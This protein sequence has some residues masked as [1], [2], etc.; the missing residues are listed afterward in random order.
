MRVRIS[1]IGR[2]GLLAAVL[3]TLCMA[4][5]Q[6]AVVF[7]PYLLVSNQPGDF[8]VAIEE[9][10]ESL[11]DGGFKVVGEYSPYENAYVL[12]VTN[13]TLKR[14]AKRSEFGGFGAV[15]R[16]AITKVNGKNQI[17]YTNPHYMGNSYRMS[18]KGM[19]KVAEQLEAALGYGEPFGSEEGL[20]P[21]ELRK[22]HYKIFM[23]YF[24][25]PYLLATF[26][27]YKDAI[28]SI[29]KGLAKGEQGTSKV[30]RVDLPGKKET[31]I[32]V[33]LTEDCSSDKY[34]MDRIDFREIK[35][36]PHLPYEIL[37]A[38]NE[39]YALHVK[40]RIAQS[41]PDLT[42]MGAKSFFSIIC[43]PPSIES[44][45]KAA[46]GQGIVDEYGDDDDYY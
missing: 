15:Q 21:K 43:A 7:K 44:A 22:Y 33:G 46:V 2:A 8:Q 13:N 11:E 5:V 9:T 25:E 28:K 4:A 6:A 18:M 27:S 14:N 23:P 39:V 34:I 37:V 1:R 32:G 3:M 41:F 29:E 42:M 30:Y 31:L 38:G 16:V 26:E 40:F 17:T 12:V 35:S 24:D 20:T 36:T 45:L 10:R 19:L